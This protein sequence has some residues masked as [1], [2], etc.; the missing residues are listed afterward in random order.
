M[1]ATHVLKMDHAFLVTQ[2]PISDNSIQQHQDASLKSDTSKVQAL[3]VQNVP[4]FV[5]HALHFITAN[6]VLKT[7][8]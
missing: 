7:T 4:L 1:T 2:Q 8:I 5:R 3:S 6:P